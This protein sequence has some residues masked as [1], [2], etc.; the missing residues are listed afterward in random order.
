MTFVNEEENK[1]ETLA[2][3][4]FS[5]GGRDANGGGGGARGII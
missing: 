4:A 2:R 5:E 3:V 1:L